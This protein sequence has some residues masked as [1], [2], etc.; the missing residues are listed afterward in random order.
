[1]DGYMM[2][3]DPNVS[4]PI[5]IDIDIV[6]E[7]NLNE[8]REKL[9]SNNN[10]KKV[11]ALEQT[12]LLLLRGEDV[13]PLLMT[14]I[15]FV[16]PSN[17][18]RLKKLV[19]LFFQI[20]DLRKPNGTLREE[21]ILVCNALR[22]DLCSP[23]EYV[24]GSVLRLLAKIGHWS[25]IQPMLSSIME[26]LNHGEPY[27]HKNALFCLTQ[28]AKK[29]GTES[30]MGCLDSIERILVGEGAACAKV[31]AYKLLEILYPAMA[32]QYILSIEATLLTAP[33]SLHLAILSSFFN[34][35]ATDAHVRTLM[36]R[37][38]IMLQN[39][40][41]NSV[42][43]AGGCVI[44]RLQSAPIEAR[45][46]AA[47]GLVKVLGE[48]DLNVKLIVLSKLNKLYS[49]SS[50][51]GDLP[52]VVEAH[53]MDIV[54]ALC[55]SSRQVSTEVISLVL[56]CLNPQNVKDIIASFKREF[57]KADEMITHSSEQAAQFRIILIKAIRYTCGLYPEASGVVY[58]ML[59]E[60]LMHSQDKT[61]PDVA[62]FFKNLTEITPQLRNDTISRL[63]KVLNGIEN[64]NVLT[65]CFWIIGEYT[66][67]DSVAGT[68]INSIYEFLAP[69]P[70]LETNKSE[71]VD[72]GRV[73]DS[74]TTIVHE[75][76][77]YGA[78][79]TESTLQNTSG[80]R[81]VITS[82][83]NI[84]L[85]CTVAQCMLKL[86]S[87]VQ[88][89]ELVAK[90]TLVVGNLMQIIQL[91]ENAHVHSHNRMQ[92]I[93]NLLV[94]LLNNP[95]QTRE[96][97]DQWLE[98][99][100][101]KY[102]ASNETNTL[103]MIGN[104]DAPLN[105]SFILGAVDSDEWSL[106]EEAEIPIKPIEAFESDGPIVPSGTRAVS[107]SSHLYQFTSVMD[108]VYIESTLDI[109]GSKVYV[110]LF[111]ENRSEH[112]LQNIRIELCAG[113]HLEL[114]STIP[115]FTLDRN[116]TFSS[117]I[118][119]RIKSSSDD[120]ICGHVYFDQSKSGIQECIMFNPIRVCMFDYILPSFM[121]PSDFRMCWGDL[122]WEKR[123]SLNAVKLGPL[124]FMKVLLEHTHMTVVAPLPPAWL[125]EAAAN[126]VD[127]W[128]AFVTTYIDYLS[129][130]EQMAPLSQQN[131][132]C[133]VNLF[134]RTIYDEEA[135]ANLNMVR[136]DNDNY[137]GSLKIRSKRQVCFIIF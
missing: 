26:N 126:A 52:N 20:F 117:Q 136:D 57:E 56:R 58:D 112:I 93:L 24:R 128:P 75:D 109:V 44:T 39:T 66:S 74:I 103:D 4:C 62:L 33:P 123:V 19:H 111:C 53:V 70:L 7:E 34:L 95:S 107:T 137:S 6:P 77:T 43:F 40:L 61:A 32:A 28:I 41:D 71:N 124:E 87:L 72:Q 31:R 105:L 119:F 131:A 84:L 100:R 17:H 63:L 127:N 86:A 101:F 132:F 9:E 79:F 96:L 12:L 120:F 97:V 69:F 81:S 114:V 94:G 5:Y 98:A 92:T 1:M 47:S 104:V 80:L 37:V 8:I 48:C 15:R 90:A 121:V 106:E 36:M 91:P 35:S 115:V 129:N 110:T 22:N 29:F 134:V 50:S 133:A 108:P 116:G 23:N 76:G 21:S 18:H 51:L 38:V 73:V 59:L 113:E 135:L 46:A 16:L 102:A 42:R 3:S 67:S 14:I 118:Q 130:L 55:S 82:D 78:H 125:K 54:R 11:K 13:S 83:C 10:K 85:Y 45:K 89:Q 49:R 30:I 88:K 60:Y 122:E 99:C 68:S 25:I 65:I 27:V 2:V 64:P